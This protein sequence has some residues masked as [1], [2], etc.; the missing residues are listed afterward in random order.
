MLIESLDFCQLRDG[1]RQGKARPG[2]NPIS[3]V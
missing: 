1:V 2:E 3:D